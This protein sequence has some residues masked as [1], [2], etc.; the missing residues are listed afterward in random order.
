MKKSTSVIVNGEQKEVPPPKKLSF[1]QVLALAFDPVPTG[2]NFLFSVTYRNGPRQN[3]EGIL[4]EGETVN[5]R[6]T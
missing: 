1:N 2:E 5:S 3:P 6:R 4:S